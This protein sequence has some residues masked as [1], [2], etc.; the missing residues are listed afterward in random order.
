[1]IFPP[2]IPAPQA[3]PLPVF[4]DWAVDWQGQKLAL[5]QGCPHWVEGKEALCSW[6]YKTLCT[7]RGSFAAYLP[8]YGVSLP[9]GLGREEAQVRLEEEVTRTL[10]RNP[11]ITGVGNFRFF[12]EDTVLKAVFVAETVYGE[13]NMEVDEG[14]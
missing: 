13:V 6:I 7:R 3:E 5:A 10:L 1:M 8:G 11:Y 14:L 4:V 2:R 12:W 9:A